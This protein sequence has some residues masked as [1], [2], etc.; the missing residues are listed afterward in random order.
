MR[1]IILFLFTFSLFANDFYEETLE[2]AYTAFTQKEYKRA[3]EKLDIIL[4][5]TEE[6]DWRYYSIRAEV[7]EALN[8]EDEA[9]EHYTFSIALNSAQP[10]VFKK[11]Y[12][13]NFKTRKPI[14]SFDYIRLYL[15]KNDNDIPMR[16]RALILAKRL[17][18]EE[19][20]RFALKK[21]KSYNTYESEKE[22]I[23][24]NI[25]KLISK[26]KYKETK[27]ECNKYLP[28]FP[29]EEILHNYLHIAQNQLDTKGKEMESILIDT[30]V[31]L[32]DN[33]KYSLKLAFYYNEK[34][35]HYQALNLFRRVFYLNLA[36]DGFALNTETVL[37]LKECYFQLQSTND[38]RA[39][40]SLTQ[41]FEQK[42]KPKLAE[43][44]S[45]RINF[46]NNREFLISILY[47]TKTNNQTDDYEK[48]REILKDRDEK[49]A[50]SE[51]MNVYSVFIYDDFRNIPKY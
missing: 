37:F 26:K 5:R 13:L 7:H 23:F 48:F 49:K 9:I 33:A 46:N 2:R 38:V 6:K 16:Y 8:Q 17:G 39:L 10:N 34:K 24:D 18:E 42:D 29:L 40:L 15:S 51:F 43:W 30:A 27:E 4:S 45:L 35:L 28:Y 20:V 41:I 36:K 22:K 3:L 31:L 44:N 47:F 14:K 1:F 32:S 19:Y 12:E 25:K 21:I 11:L 50:D